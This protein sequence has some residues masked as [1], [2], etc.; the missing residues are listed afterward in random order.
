MYSYT[1]TK[2]AFVYRLGASIALFKNDN[3]K[4]P[5]CSKSAAVIVVNSLFAKRKQKA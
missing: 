2:V 3:N 5:S 1:V 4:R